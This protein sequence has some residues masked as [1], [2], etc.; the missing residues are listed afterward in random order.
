MIQF[1]SSYWVLTAIE[2]S[3]GLGEV[4]GP[5]ECDTVAFVVELTSGGGGQG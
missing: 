5:L 1:T 2:T 3:K 4:L